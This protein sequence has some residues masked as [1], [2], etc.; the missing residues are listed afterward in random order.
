[1]STEVTIEDRVAYAV[2]LGHALGGQPGRQR[3]RRRAPG[4]GTPS[5]RVTSEPA[6]PTSATS[7]D[8]DRREGLYLA[9]LK[10]RKS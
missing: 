8:P 1:M 5:V 9:Y 4:Q 6:R 10:N 7:R 3:L 2:K